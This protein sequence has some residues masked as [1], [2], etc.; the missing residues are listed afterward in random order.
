MKDN[1]FLNELLIKVLI[2]KKKSYINSFRYITLMF[3]WLIHL[4]NRYEKFK[5]WRGL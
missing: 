3:Q 2:L 1:K 4:M 5:N